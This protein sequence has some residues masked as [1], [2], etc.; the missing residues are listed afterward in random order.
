MATGLT[1]SPDPASGL[2]DDATGSLEA[3]L[4][5]ELARLNDS[6]PGLLSSAIASRDGLALSTTGTLQADALSATSAFLLDEMDAHLGPLRAGRAREV[7]VWADG[8]PW[9]FSAIGPLPYLLAL[10]A[11]P[12]VPAAVLR[13]AGA[14]GCARMATLLAPLALP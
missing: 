10:H 9:Y 3:V 12:G 14:L 2:P 11:A 7:L 1:P 8:G 4:A 6:C 5:R 13:H